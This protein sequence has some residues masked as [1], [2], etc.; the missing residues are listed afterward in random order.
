VNNRGQ[1]QRKRVENYQTIGESLKNK[2]LTQN[3]I[4]KRIRSFTTE[5]DT[6]IFFYLSDITLWRFYIVIWSIWR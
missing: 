6:L 4:E 3:T 5:S 2:R 1:Q